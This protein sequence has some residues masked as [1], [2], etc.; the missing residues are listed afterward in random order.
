MNSARESDAEMQRAP[1]SPAPPFSSPCREA[2]MVFWGQTR[3]SCNVPGAVGTP[4][5]PAV[6][7]VRKRPEQLLGL[8]SATW[9]TPEAAA[10]PGAAMHCWHEQQG[11]RF[12]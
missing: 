1:E 6:R 8:S 4:K 12:A 2:T 10:G 5:G 9:A 11:E 3:V 7:E